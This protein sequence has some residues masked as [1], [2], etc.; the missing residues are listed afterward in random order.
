MFDPIMQRKG[1]IPA[2]LDLFADQPPQPRHDEQIGPGSWLF[3]GFA[4]PC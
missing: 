2:T 4:L 3:S 1:D